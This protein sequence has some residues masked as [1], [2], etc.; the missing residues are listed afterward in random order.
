MTAFRI[1]LSVP[2]MGTL[3]QTYVR[4]AF[5]TNWLSTAGPHI[6][7]F[8]REMADALGGGVTTLATASGTAALHLV[9]RAAGVGLG[10]RVAVA[11]LTFAGSVFPI[12]Y[13]GARPVF[14]DS[15]AAS[16]NLDPALVHEY[17][18]DAAGR[19]RLPKALIVVHLYGQHADLDPI[20]AACAEY[21]VLLIE[22]SAESLGATYKG[23]PTATTAP[24]AILSFNGNKII[25]TT[26]GGMVVARDPAL[27]A[28]MR[29][30]A[31]QAREPAVEYLHREVG[32]NYRLSNVLA[33]IGRGQLA[34][35]EERVMARRAV[36]ERYRQGLAD[37]AG[38]ALQGEAPWGRHTR[39]LSVI[40][41]D[42]ALHPGGPRR[43][44]E[45]LAERGIEAR[46]VWRP[47]H[48]QPLYS[49]AERVGGAVAE[50]LYETGLCLPSS[51]SLAPAD[52]DEVIE[53]VR[54]VLA[55]ADGAA[56]RPAP[57][58]STS[59]NPAGPRPR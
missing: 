15:D 24:L 45:A 43:V 30:W 35:L 19:G 20:A 48:T 23:R 59:S 13:L 55:R 9:L 40:Y 37:C 3:E 11:T 4:E 42:P 44:L 46:P 14:L 47:M 10:D 57:R 54:Q 1:Y 53:V 31:N 49:G 7:A 18:R 34:V 17:L 21:G 16:G 5:A 33:A 32:Y 50:R 22:D 41:L 36:A 29:L 28:R 25:T 58:S 51:S 27:V 12:Q 26:G 6:P 52:Q 8:E 2:H 38:V 39:W 56:R